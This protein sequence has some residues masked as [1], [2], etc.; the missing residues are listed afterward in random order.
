MELRG[1]FQRRQGERHAGERTL[2]GVR[3]AFLRFDLFPKMMAT[4]FGI[5]EDMRVPALHLVANARDHILE[6]ELVG[7]LGHAGVEHDLKLEVAELVRKRI[8][9]VAGDGI[10]DFVRFFDRV[11]C[12][13][14]EGL[15]RVP[16]AA[17]LGI[18]QPPHDFDQTF[19]HGKDF[20]TFR[21]DIRGV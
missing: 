17:G 13:R 6:R 18:A 9:V 3:G 8:H 5:A 12:N 11:R 1:A 7:F 4:M 14:G 19:K 15:D 16:F 2:V 20:R 10:C 21:C